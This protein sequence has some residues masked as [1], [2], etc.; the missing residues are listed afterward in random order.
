MKYL[1]LVNFAAALTCAYFLGVEVNTFDIVLLLSNGLFVA[2]DLIN[3]A[4]GKE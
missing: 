2:I 4:Q 3:Y 1:T